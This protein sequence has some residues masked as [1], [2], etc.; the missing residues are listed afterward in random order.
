MDGSS[1]TTIPAL[2]QY[3]IPEARILK[4]LVTDEQHL[5]GT[6]NSKLSR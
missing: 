3:P 4:Y 1:L 6:V 5:T 2:S